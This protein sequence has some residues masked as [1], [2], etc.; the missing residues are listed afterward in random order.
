MPVQEA[1]LKTAAVGILTYLTI[2]NEET[3]RRKLVMRYLARMDMER[4]EVRF[5]GH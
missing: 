1:E 3:T 5:I 2:T 4:T